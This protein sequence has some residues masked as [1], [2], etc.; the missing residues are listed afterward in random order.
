[1]FT[2]LL[3]T[4]Q[5]SILENFRSFTDWAE[6]GFNPPILAQSSAEALETLGHV[7]VDAVALA[8]PPAQSVRV[9]DRLHGMHML[10][11]E[12]VSDPEALRNVLQR[13]WGMIERQQEATTETGVHTAMRDT[14][15]ETFFQTLLDGLLHSETVLRNRLMT[16]DL[17][18]GADTPCLLLTLQM[19]NGDRYLQEI[20]R[21]G[22]ARLAIALRKFLQ[23]ETDDMY[24]SLSGIR[25]G[26]M[27]LLVCPL[28]PGMTPGELERAAQV[29]LARETAR[30]AE[31]LQLDLSVEETVVL[32]GLKALLKADGAV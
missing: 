7:P 4:D 22:R 24:F 21:Y 8:L 2:V 29:C 10:F 28:K 13:M 20:W 1:M 26:R 9:Y 6:L 23:G 27:R 12:P 17:P 32:D 18:V 16:L 11:L 31:Y 25:A 30:I 19:D 5:G 3:A 14:L 15:V